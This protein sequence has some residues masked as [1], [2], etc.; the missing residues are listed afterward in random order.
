[1]IDRAAD[2]WEILCNRDMRRALIRHRVIPDAQ[3]F[4]LSA[5]MRWAAPLLWRIRPDPS[6]LESTTR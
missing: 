4:P 6:I 3:S 1:M 5:A 2:L